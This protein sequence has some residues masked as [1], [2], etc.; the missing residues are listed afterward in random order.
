[1]K[2]EVLVKHFENN[3][4]EY[5]NITKTIEDKV[6]KILSDVKVFLELALLS[7]IESMRSDPDKYCSLIYYDDNKS[8]SSTTRDND[9]QVHHYPLY[10]HRQQPHPSPYYDYDIEDCKAILLE[11]AEKLY[12]NMTKKVVCEP[13]NEIVSKTYVTSLPVLPLENKQ[14]Q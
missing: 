1:M 13:V 4:E 9:N 12:A 8:L 10:M 2:Q 6:H 7:I 14:E 11:E 5:I 3:N